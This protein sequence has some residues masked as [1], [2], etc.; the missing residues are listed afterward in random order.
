MSTI[1]VKPAD[2][3]DDNSYGEYHNDILRYFVPFGSVRLNL[4]LYK[5]QQIQV[6]GT[7]KMIH[8]ASRK[9][10]KTVLE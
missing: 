7:I 1:K 5:N 8:W 4:S 9:L 6:G 2:G 3:E 10:N